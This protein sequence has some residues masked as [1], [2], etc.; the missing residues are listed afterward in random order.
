MSISSEQLVYLARMLMISDGLISTIRQIGGNLVQQQQKISKEDLNKYKRKFRKAW[1]T[2]AKRNKIKY[3][4]LSK[5]P[6][7]YRSTLVSRYYLSKAREILAEG[8][9]IYEA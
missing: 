6:R 7:L 9:S 4:E 2:A 5:V 3:D 8:A 1:R